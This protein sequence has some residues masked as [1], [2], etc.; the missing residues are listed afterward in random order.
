MCALLVAVG[1]VVG[2]LGVSSLLEGASNSTSSRALGGEIEPRPQTYVSGYE[3]IR[4]MPHDK[5]MF[6][7]GLAFAPDGRLFE[8]DGLYHYSLIREVDVET[9]KSLQT[10]SNPSSVFGEGLVVHD[11]RLIQLSWKENIIHELRLADFALI[12]AVTK[13]IG[14]EGWGLAS[15]GS[16]L[17]ITDSG[18]E[19]FHVHP[20]TYEV[21]KKLP[22]VDPELTL[23]GR[24]QRIHG[25]NELEWVEGELWGNVYPMYQGKHSDC[26]VRIDP[27]TG[28][29]LGW[30]DLRGLTGKQHS[31]VRTSPQHYPLNGIAYHGPSRRL[32]VTGK[33]WDHM[34]Q[35]RITPKDDGPADVLNYCSLGLSAH[36]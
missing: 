7:Q 20:T 2:W 5:N 29:V 13:R 15:D 14:A 11:D 1:G 3:I 32:Y 21:L 8:S 9:G 36:L 33:K 19:L 30:I 18:Y 34:Y 4:T 24:A 10:F 22:I 27:G 26:I 25:V 35:V 28:Q 23:R 17:Y 6:T 12:Q 16:T 31:L